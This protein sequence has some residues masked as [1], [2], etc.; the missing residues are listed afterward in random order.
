[1]VYPIRAQIYSVAKK[2]CPFGYSDY[3]KCLPYKRDKTKGT[4]GTV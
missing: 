1:M 3:T 4:Y 2:A